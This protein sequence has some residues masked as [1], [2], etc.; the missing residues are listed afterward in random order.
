MT[1]LATKPRSLAESALHY[2]ALGWSVIPLHD[3]RQGMVPDPQRPDRFISGL[4]CSCGKDCGNSRGKH[5]RLNE[6]QKHATDDVEQV[7]RWWQSFP[8]ANIGVR[9]G[10]ASGIVGIDIDPPNGEQALLEVSNGDLPP[11]LEMRT[12]KGRRLLYGIPENLEVEPQTVAMRDAD[13]QETIRLQGGATGAQCVMPPSMHYLGHRYEWIR[14]P[15]QYAIALMP[16]WLVVEMCRPKQPDWNDAGDRRPIDG[17]EPWS[18]FNKRDSWHEWLMHWGYKPAGGSGDT[19]YYTRPGKNGGISVSVG[20]YQCR[21]GT[22]ALYTFSGNCPSLPGA[23]CYDLFGA[24]TRIEH[25]GD[26]TAAARMLLD[27]GY[28]ERKSRLEDRVKQLEA[29]VATLGSRLDRAAQLVSD[30]MRRI[31]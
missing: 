27:K 18:A 23:K 3:L 14:G 21:D 28:G 17:T 30:L 5:P 11:T 31:A 24:Y 10:S 9:L 4:L 15:E 22:P 26:F 16:Q 1:A 25:G 12:G 7:E 2:A 8:H 6:W 19:R 29:Q 13:S 20:H